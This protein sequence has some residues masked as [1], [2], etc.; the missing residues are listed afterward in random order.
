MQ[1]D[2]KREVTVLVAEDDKNLKRLIKSQLKS[3]G[4]E[5]IGERRAAVDETGF[6]LVDEQK[7]VGLADIEIDHVQGAVVETG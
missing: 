4:F 7:G 3:F 1:S 6:A 2:L 5:R